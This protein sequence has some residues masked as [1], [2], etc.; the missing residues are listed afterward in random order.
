[1]FPISHPYLFELQKWVTKRSDITLKVISHSSSSM[2][3]ENI[4]E[5]LDFGDILVPANRMVA[6]TYNNLA[7]VIC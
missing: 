4:L 1:M 3:G 5:I 2:I 6:P 7:K